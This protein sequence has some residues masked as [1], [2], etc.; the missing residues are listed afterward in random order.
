MLNNWTIVLLQTMKNITYDSTA[1]NSI[2]IMRIYA[3]VHHK[4][5]SIGSM[6]GDTPCT[7]L[8]ISCK[9]LSL[10]TRIISSSLR[11]ETQNFWCRIINKLTNESSQFNLVTRFW[12]TLW[13][14]EIIFLL[15]KLLICL[16]LHNQMKNLFIQ[17]VCPWYIFYIFDWITQK[18]GNCKMSTH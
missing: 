11:L 18:N 13:K 16:L 15:I 17:P 4:S 14:T 7:M 3:W 6:F 10:F 1:D 12:H 8:Q 2:C 5:R 9:L